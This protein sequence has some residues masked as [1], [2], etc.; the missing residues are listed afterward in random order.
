MTGAVSVI[1]GFLATLVSLYSTVIFIRII[2][3]WIPGAEYGKFGEALRMITDPYLNWFRRFTFLRLGTI[4][5][6]VLGAFISLSILSSIF[7]FIS[8]AGR[9][10]FGIILAFIIQAVASAAGFIMGLFLFMMLF[11]LIG[12]YMRLNSL[13]RV[14]FSLD[15]L[16]QPILHPIMRKLFPNRIVPY[17][18]TLLGGA[19]SLFVLMLLGRFLVNLLI[20]LV[21][22]IP[23]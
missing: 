13:D 8:R 19:G 22:R 17:G 1:F 4:D 21:V 11:R 15:A 23:F 9:I 14:W 2:M 20:M 16:L 7:N 12:L 5:F 18:T 10:S 3:T 6:S